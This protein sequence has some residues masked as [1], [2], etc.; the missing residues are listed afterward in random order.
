MEEWRI[1]SLILNVQIITIFN[2]LFVCLFIHILPL[3]FLQRG[4][5]AQW[6][7]EAGDGGCSRGLSPS[8]IWQGELP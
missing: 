1:Y 6:L 2:I 7:K 8:T 5:V 3:L 4:V